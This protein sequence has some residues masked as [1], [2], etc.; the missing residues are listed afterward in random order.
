MTVRVPTSGESLASHAVLLE[1]LTVL[2]SYVDGMVVIG[3]WV[4]EIMFPRRGH[5]GSLDVDLAV[6][7]RAVNP[8]A[9]GSIRTRLAQAGY[10]QVEPCM[11][12]FTKALAAE[13]GAVTVKLDLVAGEDD[14]APNGV[15]R[16]LVQ[17][18]LLGRLRGV[19]LALDHAVT[20][21]LAGKM[22]DGAENTVRARVADIPAF[23]CMKALALNERMKEKDAYDIYFCLKHFEGGP[24]MLARA[25]RGM[26]AAPRA[27]EAL[28]VLRVKFESIGSVGPRWAARVSSGQGEDAEFVAR[29]AFERA[30]AFLRALEGSVR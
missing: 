29:D 3:G 7:G 14:G 25:A 11:G 10:T 15:E 24:A 21:S 22:P 5:I 4:P 26:L 17:D 1:V 20:M 30:G 8:D 18:L 9:Y 23:I 12:V 6:D 19:E 28:E 13:S 2:G 27:A 16:M